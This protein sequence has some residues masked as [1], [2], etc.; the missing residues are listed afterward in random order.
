[1]KSLDSAGVLVPCFEPD[2]WRRAR[3]SVYQE[4]ASVLV[5]ATTWN[6]TGTE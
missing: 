6:D 3:L 2:E 1:M 5:G 4:F